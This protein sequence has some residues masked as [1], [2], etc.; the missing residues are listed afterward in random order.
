M[1]YYAKIFQIMP[2]AGPRRPPEQTKK[3]E[4]IY[5]NVE[6]QFLFLRLCNKSAAGPERSGGKLWGSGE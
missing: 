1:G 6:K 3:E 5:E 4:G 2:F